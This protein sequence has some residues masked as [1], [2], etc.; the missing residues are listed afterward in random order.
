MARFIPTRTPSFL[1]GDSLFCVNFWRKK[2]TTRFAALSASALF[3][4]SNVQCPSVR[5]KLG[6]RKGEARGARY[7]AWGAQRRIRLLKP[8]AGEKFGEKLKRSF[9]RMLN[10]KWAYISFLIG[11]KTIIFFTGKVTYF[12][13]KATYSEVR[14]VR[15]SGSTGHC[16]ADITSYPQ[17][18][19]KSQ[20]HG[21]PCHLC[22]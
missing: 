20:R 9:G 16:T 1:Q 2:C 5:R 17:R 12:C 14:R 22:G 19:S 11:P 3:R 8:A 15:W 10:I 13:R 21:V 18:P 7:I 6:G 4:P